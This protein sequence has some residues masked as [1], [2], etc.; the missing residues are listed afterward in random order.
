M[1]PTFFGLDA[2]TRALMA[3]QEAV[4]V[5]NQ[6]ISNASTPGYSK[7]TPV[8]TAFDPY[9]DPAFDR[10][11]LNGQLGT[12]AIVS[13][14]KRAV[15][16]MLNAQIRAGS[17]ASGS[18]QVMDDLYNQIQSIFDDPSNQAINTATSNFFNAVHDLA[19]QPEATDARTSLQ[20]QG[21]TLASA[22]G[23]R[24]NQLTSLQGNLNTKVRTIIADI[25]NTTKQ[26]ALLNSQITVVKGIGDNANDLMDKRDLLVDHLSTLIDT[27]DVKNAD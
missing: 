11:V 13:T 25:N 19:N 2:V 16:E 15:D 27:K 3:Q 1:L 26:I 23:Y 18:L 4:D 10:P 14:V 8:V 20:Q 12:G 22:I 9:T 5:V 24:Y 17:Q 6:N 21:V 7:Q